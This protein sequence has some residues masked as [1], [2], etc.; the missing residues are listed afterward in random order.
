M[1]GSA[2]GAAPTADKTDVLMASAEEAVC[3]VQPVT[4]E[5]ERNECS[6]SAHAGNASNGRSATP[7]I[8]AI[9]SGTIDGGASS[10]ERQTTRII[11]KPRRHKGDLTDDEDIE[12]RLEDDGSSE[13]SGD[14]DDEGE[15]RKSKSGGAKPHASGGKQAAAT[16][17]R[18][19]TTSGSNRKVRK[20]SFGIACV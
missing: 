11:R 1:E 3:Q 13:A 12:D 15:R 10:T 18:S 6:N 9:G 2:P 4:S 7:T 17:A 20:K 19:K 5:T 16:N 14:D 8:S